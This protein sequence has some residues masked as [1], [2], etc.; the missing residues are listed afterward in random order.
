MPSSA[1]R[2]DLQLTVA[3]TAEKVCMIE[4]GANE[5]DDDT[6][7]EAI[8]KGFA[9]VQKMVAFIKEVQAEI[10]KPKFTFESQ[11]IRSRS[12][13]EAIK[14]EFIEDVRAA[15]DTDDKNIRDER[16]RPIYDRRACRSIDEKYPEQER[17]AG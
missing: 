8:M 7:L 2:A 13:F 16:L 5:V 9:E 17:Y 6:M 1:R 12:C 14:D 10:G 11:E 15:L 3:G 4:A